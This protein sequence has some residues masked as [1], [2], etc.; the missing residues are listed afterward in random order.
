MS[1]VAASPST[2][3]WNRTYPM[4]L[5][6]HSPIVQCWTAKQVSDSRAAVRAT[7]SVTAGSLGARTCRTRAA[8][9]DM[10]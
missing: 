4:K 6:A 1:G 9:S 3:R 2:V 7:A 10:M 5:A 8:S